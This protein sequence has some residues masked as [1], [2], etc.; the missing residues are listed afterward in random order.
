MSTSESQQSL[1]TA[2]LSLETTAALERLS[3]LRGFENFP[4]LKFFL[5]HHDRS[6]NSISLRVFCSSVYNFV[7][8]RKLHGEIE[9]WINFAALYLRYYLASG[10][11]L[12]PDRVKLCFEQRISSQE[13]RGYAALYPQRTDEHHVLLK[14]FYDITFDHTFSFISPV[15]PCSLERSFFPSSLKFKVL[16]HS[17]DSEIYYY[18]AGFTLYV[19]TFYN[20]GAI[21]FYADVSVGY[22]NVGPIVEKYRA[23]CEVM[24]TDLANETILLAHSIDDGEQLRKVLLLFI[25]LCDE[26]DFPSYFSFTVG[27]FRLTDP[28]LHLPDQLRILLLRKIFQLSCAPMVFHELLRS[29]TVEGLDVDYFYPKTLELIFEAVRREITYKGL[30]MATDSESPLALASSIDTTLLRWSGSYYSMWPLPEFPARYGRLDYCDSRKMYILQSS[31]FYIDR[32]ADLSPVDTVSSF[33]DFAR[34]VGL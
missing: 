13:W 27:A 26:R 2:G 12:Y 22:I 14:R 7:M 8:H 1:D 25:A 28:P 33:S 19:H 10:N 34:L 15:P 5:L 32:V 9:V 3:R 30:L 6:N 24:C 17:T 16:F 29:I 20:K 4:F 18:A 23:L 21:S 11:V 31:C